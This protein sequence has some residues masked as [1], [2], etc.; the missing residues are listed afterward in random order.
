MQNNL[1]N[2][3]QYAASGHPVANNLRALDAY[4][5]ALKARSRENTPLQYANTISN[6]ANCLSNLPDD[7]ASPDFGAA[8]NLGKAREL[9]AEA[10]EIFVTNGEIEKAKMAAE[11]GFQIARE[12]MGARRE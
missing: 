7:P 4:A 6:M 8:K 10:R 2:A 11:A 1:G 12:L 9:Y 5:E 3:L